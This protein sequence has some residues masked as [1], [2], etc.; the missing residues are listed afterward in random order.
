VP[1][2]PKRFGKYQILEAIGQGAWGTVYRAWDAQG[3]R[4][5]ALRV[6]DP[7]LTRDPLLVQHLHA[8]ARVAASLEHPH[9][10]RVYDAGEEQGWHWIATEYIVGGTLAGLLK[11]RRPLPLSAACTVVRQVAAAL[12][13]L[14]D[15]GVIHHDVQPSS[16]FLQTTPEQGGR[17]KLA[18]PVLARAARASHAQGRARTGM[19]HY[20]SP[21]QARGEATDAR[22]DVYS[23]GVV[24]YEMLAG[25]TPFGGEEFLQAEE[26][27]PPFVSQDVQGAISQ[28]LARDPARRFPSAGAFAR[29]LDAA[30]Q[31]PLRSAGAERPAPPP[32]PPPPLVEGR[33]RSRWAAYAL[34]CS[35]GL[36]VMA[37]ACVA[38]VVAGMW[39]GA[40]SLLSLLSPVTPSRPAQA[41]SPP[42]S[43]LTAET[44]APTAASQPETVPTIALSPASGPSGTRVQVRGYTFTPHD[45]ALLTWDGH[46]ITPT[47]PIHVV[48]DA[49]G[50][51]QAS[52][53]APTDSPGGHTITVGTAHG[54]AAA[55]FIITTGEGQPPD[56][57][58]LAPP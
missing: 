19:A 52:F 24:A 16:I 22:S 31:C 34:G 23:L 26:L 35:T 40:A 33:K 5:V 21:E 48:V 13:H 36:V 11:P 10:V 56:A 4:V 44:P 58:D 43:T 41:T 39:V 37:L 28:A 18:A 2:M 3:Q 38:L 57:P 51:F 7:A 50:R 8:A 42:R 45:V 53:Y 1:E 47:Q 25:R 29:A 20:L 27:P 46:V 9:L 6:L 32:P 55:A 15:R 14:H 30:A 17:V 54:T 12:D 49:N